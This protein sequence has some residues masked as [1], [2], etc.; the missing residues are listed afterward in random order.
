MKRATIFMTLYLCIIAF[1]SA[2][3]AEI[4]G[5]IINQ[6]NEPVEY[7]NVQLLNADSTFIKGTASDKNGK[8][9]LEA[10]PFKTYLII[11]SA[12]GYDPLKIDIK[13]IKEK[14]ELGELILKESAVALDEVTIS[15]NRVIHKIDRQI[16]YP[17]PIALQTSNN[18]LELLYKMALPRVIVN[19]SD[20]SVA[21]TGNESARLRINNIDADANQVAAI[22]AKDIIRI[23]YYDNPGVR[24]KENAIID[25]IV[26]RRESGGYLSTD[27]KNAPYM[28]FGNDMLSFKTNYK[29][30]EWSA[31]YNI[32]YHNFKKQKTEKTKEFNF[33]E[34]SFLQSTEGIPSA[35]GFQNHTVNL[36]YNYTIANKRAFNVTLL[37]S[38]LNEK[39]D[40]QNKIQ[41]SNNPSVSFHS[42]THFN[43]KEKS[44][45]LDLYYK[46]NI[47]KNQTIYFNLVA[48]YIHT[49]YA[50]DYREWNNANEQ[51]SRLTNYITGNKYSIIGESNHQIKWENWSLY[52]GVN[53][54]AGFSRNDYE[55]QDNFEK[56]SLN[57][58]DLYFYSQLQGKINKL[59]IGIGL[60]GAFSSFNDQ[61]NNYHFWT[62][63]PFLSLAYPL[64]KNTSIRYRFDVDQQNPYLTNL[65]DVIL[66]TDQ[67]TATK[68]NPALRPF[69]IYRNQLLISFQKNKFQCY[70]MGYQQYYAKAIMEDIYLDKT[71]S[72][73]IET[74]N[75]QKYY[76]LVLA[77]GGINW[78]IITEMLSFNL[79]GQLCWMDS[80]GNSYHHKYTAYSGNGQLNFN[81]K[82]WRANVG[83]NSR[84]NTLWGET[85]SYGEWR[86]TAEIGYKHKELY[87]GI[88]A[89][90][91]LTNKTS[92]GIKNLSALT[93]GTSW[94]Y[95][96]DAAPLFNLKL[97]WNFS[98]GKQSKV[99]Q[100]TVQNKDTDNGITVK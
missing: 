52:S 2:Q 8:I 23:D 18:A 97:A 40:E 27:L 48:G 47:S 20:K 71:S 78:E 3:Q 86:S 41:Y 33:P 44:P 87:I 35:S 16:T 10:V 45:T 9:K 17:S 91:L 56:R 28:A 46:E 49:D 25:F 14:L 50:Y 85:I 100:K 72:V 12:L 6:K 66:N 7:A 68:G 53:Y 96:Y 54:K 30:S 38:F 11:I 32:D 62:F 89:N 95:I 64:G 15:A 22:Q 99:E 19:T 57:N 70:L 75:N 94:T 5:K 92:N 34:N 13:E 74:Q 58:S 79:N 43:I 24:V 31:F 59:S 55:I 4:T 29:N 42:L 88:E 39:T 76:H 77:S 81:Y 82:K 73:F 80:K 84:F 37:S 90:N 21:L 93:P 1:I 83:I 69:R 60:G 67:Y 65:S 98:W 61:S 36:N 26:K 51:K 63:K